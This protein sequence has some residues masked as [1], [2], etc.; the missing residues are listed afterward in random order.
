MLNRPGR[1]PQHFHGFLVFAHRCKHPCNCKPRGMRSVCRASHLIQ[2]GSH[3]PLLQL[4]LDLAV[5]GR[6]ARANARSPAGASVIYAWC[7]DLQN[8]GAVLLEARRCILH[9]DIAERAPKAGNTTQH[10]FVA[11][12]RKLHPERLEVPVR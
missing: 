6:Q 5:V 1:L 7:E 4:L 2:R 9:S 11:G 3:Q 8:V 12:L 10:R